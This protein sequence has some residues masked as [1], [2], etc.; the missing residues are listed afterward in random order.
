MLI[1]N[2][3]ASALADGKASANSC[4]VIDIEAR[5]V[6]VLLKQWPVT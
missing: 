6:E 5:Q 2:I 1:G 4:V 3:N